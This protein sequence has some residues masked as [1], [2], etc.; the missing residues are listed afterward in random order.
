VLKFE[1][2]KL[3]GGILHR[4]TDI[5]KS[6]PEFSFP[7]RNSEQVAACVIL[8]TIGVFCVEC[9]RST[10][11]RRSKL[12]NPNRVQVAKIIGDCEPVDSRVEGCNPDDVDGL[13][14]VEAGHE[15]SFS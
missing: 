6:N 5:A 7:I 8:Y 12:G 3:E 1:I 10:Q 9:H 4:Y 11:Q 15:I 2:S 14:L 13:V